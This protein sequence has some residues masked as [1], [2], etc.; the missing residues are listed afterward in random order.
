MIPPLQVKHRDFTV[1]FI[2][3]LQPKIYLEIFSWH[4][5]RIDIKKLELIVALSQFSHRV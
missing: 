5:L 3:M 2:L 1:D 4:P